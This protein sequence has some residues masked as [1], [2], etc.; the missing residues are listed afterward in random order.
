MAIEPAADFQLENTLSHRPGIIRR[1]GMSGKTR[2]GKHKQ[3]QQEN[4]YH[5]YVFSL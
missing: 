3:A 4:H 5:H 2:R 1:E